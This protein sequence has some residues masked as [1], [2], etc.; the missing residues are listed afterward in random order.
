M[1]DLQRLKRVYKHLIN[2]GIANTQTEIAQKIGVTK[3]Y[4]S[5]VG[6]NADLNESF[7]NK[8]ITLDNNLNKVWILKGRGEML[9][10]ESSNLNE[11]SVIYNDKIEVSREEYFEMKRQISDLIIT[12]RELAVSNR[13]LSK[14]NST[15]SEVI[16]K[17]NTAD[18]A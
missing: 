18:T 11:P 6:S 10:S 14:T 5:S 4:L 17:K 12:N 8:L 16:S 13:T 15:L 3:S 9:L 1:T 7:V 2:Q